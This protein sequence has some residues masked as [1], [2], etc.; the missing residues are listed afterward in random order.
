VLGVH[1]GRHPELEDVHACLRDI[2]A[3]L[4]PHMRKEEQVLFP[5]I[6]ELARASELPAFHCGTVRNP[7]AVMLMEHDQVG[8]VLARMRSLCDGY[9]P[10]ADAC[11]SYVALFAGLEELEEDTR[12]HVHKENNLLFPAV[13]DLEARLTP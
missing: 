3:D 5:M 13:L 1:G 7:I 10:P 11:A 4:E 12:L 6:R 9:Q 2:R 8:E